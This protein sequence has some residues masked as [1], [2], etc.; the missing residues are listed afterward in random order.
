MRGAVAP[1][2]AETGKKPVVAVLLS[3]L[4]VGLGQFYNGDIKK[5]AVMLAVA[6]LGGVATAGLAWLGAAVWS[7]VDAYQ[8][9][10]G[11]WGR[12]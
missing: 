6:I 2:T 12:W 9:A 5:G 3:V 8:V 1:A 11:K 7:V 10:A 4:I